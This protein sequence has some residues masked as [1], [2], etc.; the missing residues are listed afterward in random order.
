MYFHIIFGTKNRVPCIAADWEER[1][2]A[3]LGGAIRNIG[4]KALAIGG[5]GDHVHLAASL[6]P[7][8]FLPDLMRDLKRQ[9]SRWVHEDIG[10][11][12]FDWQDGYGVFTVS[13]SNVEEVVKYVLN[14]REHH[15]TRTFR[16]EY[17]AFLKA[18]MVEYKDEYV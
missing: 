4:G 7:M 18:H 16:E 15:R 2:H 5:Y 10:L 17:V 9:S 13:F 1:L 6:K 14:Q 11:R 3:Y 8:H 12:S